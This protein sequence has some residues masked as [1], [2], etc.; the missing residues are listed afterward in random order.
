M[1]FVLE[2]KKKVYFKNL[3]TLHFKCNECHQTVHF[4]TMK[5]VNF[6]L[7]I[8]FLVGTLKSHDTYKYFSGHNR[9]FV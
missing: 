8:F 4:K 3:M 7:Y 9:Q 1:Y 5:M 6:M 2:T